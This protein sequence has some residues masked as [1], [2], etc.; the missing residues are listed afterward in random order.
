METPTYV[1]MIGVLAYLNSLRALSS[2][3]LMIESSAMTFRLDRAVT[4]VGTMRVTSK[5]AFRAG[6]DTGARGNDQITEE[7]KQQASKRCDERIKT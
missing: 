5:V 3:V 1:L 6:C 2:S 7:Q 4:P